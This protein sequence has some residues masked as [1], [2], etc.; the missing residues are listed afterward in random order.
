MSATQPIGV[1]PAPVNSEE[2]VRAQLDAL[3]QGAIDTNTFLSNVK[4]RARSQPDYDWEVFSLIDQYYRRGKIELEVFR[5]LKDGIAEFILGPKDPESPAVKQAQKTQAPAPAP[6]S[7]APTLH[8]VV[9]PSPKAATA[10]PAPAAASPAPVKSAPANPPAAPSI[11]PAPI[12]APMQAA[13]PAATYAATP[14]PLPAATPPATPPAPPPVA[15]VVVPAAIAPAPVRAPAPPPAP[16][17]TPSYTYAAQTIAI[18]AQPQPQ[19]PSTRAPAADPAREAQVGDLLRNRY[20][21]ELLIGKGTSGNVFEANDP[22][23]LNLPPAGKRVA[24]KV[25]HPDPRGVYI[26]Q[27]RQE[28]HSL[29]TLSHPNI[30]RSFDFDREGGLAFFTMELLN[31]EH[32]HN[33]LRMRGAPLAREHAFAIIRDAADAV[34]YAHSRGIVHGDLNPR[35][36][37]LT[38]RG[39]MRVLRFGAWNRLSGNEEVSQFEQASAVPDTGRYASCEVLQGNRPNDSDDLYSLSCLAY[40]LLSGRHAYAD[41]TSI[42]ARAERKRP[43]RPGGLTYRQWVTLRSGLQTD[44]RRR[45]GDVRAWL[46]GMEL[47]AAAKHLPPLNE[48]TEPP[49]IKSSRWQWPVAAVVILAL[50]AVGYWVY[51]QASPFGW[52]ISGDSTAQDAA[53][54][55]DADVT[56]SD[57]TS[58]PAT[59]N[60]APPNAT[61][62]YTSP[63]TA[64]PPAASP[65]SGRQTPTTGSNASQRPLTPPPVA[66]PVPPAKPLAAAPPA[67]AAGATAAS[68]SAAHSTPVSQA[69]ARVEMAADTLDASPTDS[70]V[71]VTVRR[72]GNLHGPTSF[73]WWTESGTA[74]PGVDFAPV[75]PHVMQMP[76]GESVTQL[77][78]V[79]LPA[80]RAQDKGF[81]VGIEETDGGAQIGARSL[82][83]ITLPAT[84]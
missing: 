30:V 59:A 76:D 12:P 21:L 65:P 8:S 25:M 55:P 67:V 3:A 26:E 9:S 80:D 47:S 41:R 50:I 56:A 46:D 71:H 2:A 45:P 58:N 13:P 78:V 52:R 81:Y 14:A 29:Q 54:T 15:A 49:I 40:L 44:A 33:V 27:L 37:F 63:A 84:R 83:Q 51:T 22:L 24:I 20:R 17:P 16:A 28:F 10:Q 4:A 32:L 39:E 60:T 23:R 69:P 48:L 31:G 38:T 7:H 62:S 18:Q 1:D 77:S 19:A 6:T 42:E 34:A 35:N 57:A 11:A 75:L 36:I 72:K 43:R 5:T 53:P 74:K 82:T 68:G 66:H 61:S 70:V 73:T 64:Q 79:L